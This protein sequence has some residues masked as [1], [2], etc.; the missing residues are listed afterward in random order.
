MTSMKRNWHGGF[1]SDTIIAV[2]T[3]DENNSVKIKFKYSKSTCMFICFFSFRCAILVSIT[4]KRCMARMIEDLK[5][6][7]GG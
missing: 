2:M 4:L 1:I 5:L 6:D 7:K 3:R